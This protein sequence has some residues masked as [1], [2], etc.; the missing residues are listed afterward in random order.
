MVY[1]Q[2]NESRNLLMLQTGLK[3]QLKC[4]AEVEFVYNY[5]LFY[6][7]FVGKGNRKPRQNKRESLKERK[8]LVVEG[9]KEN[10]S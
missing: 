1:K 2:F 6:N 9:E 3:P 7:Y 5:Q 8:Y 4:V 10:V